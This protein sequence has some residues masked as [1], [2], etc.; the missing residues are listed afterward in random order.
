MMLHDL[1]DHKEEFRSIYSRIS[2]T[3]LLAEIHSRI[4]RLVDVTSNSANEKISKIKKAF[5]KAGG[6]EL[7]EYYYIQGEHSDKKQIP[8]APDLLVS[9]FRYEKL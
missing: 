9:D 5:V 6:K 4:D 8:L 3:G 7:A 2:T 1:V